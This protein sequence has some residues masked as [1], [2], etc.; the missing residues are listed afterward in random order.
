MLVLCGWLVLMI[1]EVYFNL[2]FYDFMI[3][4]FK[5]LTPHPHYSLPNSFLIF[6]AHEMSTTIFLSDIHIKENAL[7][8]TP[9][10]LPLSVKNVV[11]TDH[12]QILVPWTFKW[13]S[14]IFLS[15]KDFHPLK[16][17]AGNQFKLNILPA[18][19][20]WSIPFSCWSQCAASLVIHH[21]YCLLQPQ[22]MCH[23]QLFTRNTFLL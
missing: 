22:P 18:N 15:S 1:S 4:W 13:F 10:S 21:L 5:T 3:L 16:C 6:T 17:F 7:C 19:I 8:L 11:L 12:M 14:K 9:S 23:L 20:K 2:W